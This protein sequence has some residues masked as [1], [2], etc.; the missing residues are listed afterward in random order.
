MFSNKR[1]QLIVLYDEGV[2]RFVSRRRMFAEMEKGIDPHHEYFRF[3]QRMQN[4]DLIEEEFEDRFWDRP[5]AL[6]ECL[7]I[8][9]E[10][11]GAFVDMLAEK[12][13]CKI[14]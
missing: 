4:P 5:H 12:L 10:A 2:R 13:T 7:S 8:S 14:S 11:M 9:E 3:Y 6:E 1:K